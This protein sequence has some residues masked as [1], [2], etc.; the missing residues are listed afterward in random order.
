M[1]EELLKR[2]AVIRDETADSANTATR[3]GSLF[4][5]I[6]QAEETALAGKVDAEDGYALADQDQ[7][8]AANWCGVRILQDNTTSLPFLKVAADGTNGY[9]LSHIVDGETYRRN[10]YIPLATD[11]M[12]GVMS[13]SDHADLTTA[14]EDIDA[15]F[16]ASEETGK[17]VAA[18]Q[19]TADTATSTATS[20]ANTASAAA[21]SI[22]QRAS[23]LVLPISGIDSL[24]S[25]VEPIGIAVHDVA[26][27]GLPVYSTK[28]NAFVVAYNLKKYASWSG[29]TDIPNADAYGSTKVLYFDGEKIYRHTGTALVEVTADTSPLE[30]RIAALEAA[31]KALADETL[32]TI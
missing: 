6:L 15:L 27:G 24:I 10:A 17:A 20:A 13:A 9:V 11:S 1:N 21:L 26:Y 5:D 29:F 14:L 7:L 22:S 28:L 12:P 23:A 30:A 8:H 32:I 4:V 16:N 19:S 31:L 18:A 3:V 25:S 2:A